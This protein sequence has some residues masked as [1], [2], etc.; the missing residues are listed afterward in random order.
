MLL[1]LGIQVNATE[2]GLNHAKISLLQRQNIEI[3]LRMQ[4]TS[5]TSSVL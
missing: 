1:V 4:E 2:A 3:F 5:L